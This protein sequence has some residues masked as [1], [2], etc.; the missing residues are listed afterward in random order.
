MS[1]GE[2]IPSS[3]RWDADLASRSADLRGLAELDRNVGIAVGR[4]DPGDADIAVRAKDVGPVRGAG[5]EH[6]VHFHVVDPA[7]QIAD[8]LARP[9]IEVAA[10]VQRWPVGM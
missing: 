4:D 10:E 7:G 9:R 6:R 8:V 5:H 3:T 1:S 2:G